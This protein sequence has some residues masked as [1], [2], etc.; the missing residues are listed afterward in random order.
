MIRHRTDAQVIASA[1]QMDA[2]LAAGLDPTVL[3]ALVEL[4]AVWHDTGTLPTASPEVAAI[5]GHPAVGEWDAVFVT[6]L[7]RKLSVPRRSVP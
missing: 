3:A 5:L 7:R 1:A 4:R 2:A 6:A